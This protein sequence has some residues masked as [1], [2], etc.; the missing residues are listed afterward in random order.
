[1][2]HSRSSSIAGEEG[3]AAFDFSEEDHGARDSVN[4]DTSLPQERNKASPNRTPVLSRDH[5]RDWDADA[6]TLSDA[7]E[8]L[9]T[10]VN[11]LKQKE[12]EYGNK[13]NSAPMTPALAQELSEKL[14][15]PL[16]L[17]AEV[18][19]SQRGGT[20]DSESYLGGSADV[21][22][23]TIHEVCHDIKDESS[24]ATHTSK[25][26]ET[27]KQAFNAGLR[28]G[29]G[30]STKSNNSNNSNT[31]NESGMSPSAS[32][33]QMLGQVEAELELD[34]EAGQREVV[35]PQMLRGQSN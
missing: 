10:L 25:M 13:S 35:K 2:K 8:Q 3:A 29:R 32:R 22:M 17:L 6:S 16:T 28:V 12:A 21:S 7:S 1:M 15:G 19:K 18:A 23:P 34:L 4:D 24:I 9:Q 31:D 33:K 26:L 11:Y 27:F 20:M 30:E 5:T 14:A